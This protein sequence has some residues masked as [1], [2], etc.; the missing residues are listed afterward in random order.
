MKKAYYII[1]IA[2]AHLAA[3][4]TSAPEILQDMD[5]KLNVFVQDMQG[6][7]PSCTKVSYDPSSDRQWSFEVGDCFG[8]FVLDAQNDIVQSNV[9]VYCSGL[10]NDG[11]AVW[12]IFKSISQEGSSSNLP[13]SEVLGSGSRY[14]AYFPYT[15][16]MDNVGNVEQLKSFVQQTGSSLP[17]DQ[18]LSIT[19]CDLLVASNVPDA[20]YGAVSVSGKHVNLTFAH[21]YS[22]LMFDLPSGS[23]KYDYFFGDKDFTPFLLASLEESD[24]YAF[25]FIPG[26]VLDITIKFVHEGKLYKYETGNR[27]NLWPMVT[28]AGH[29]YYLDKSLPAVPYSVA[30]DMGTSVLWSSFNLGAEKV[31][32]VTI[33]TVREYA[34]DYLMW[35]VNQ[36]TSSV[37]NTPYRNYC[38]AFTTGTKPSELPAGYDYSGDVNYDAATALWGGKWRTP[39][40]QEWQELFAACTYIATNSSITFTSKTTGNTLVF[41]YAGYSNGTPVELTKGYY[42]TSD[43]NP[44]NI[45]K[46]YSVTFASNLS[47]RLHPV[48]DR[49][50]G[51]P[52]RPVCS[53]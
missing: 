16:S 28:A 45:A 14:Y 46:A 27:K 31:P 1:L 3:G 9:K 21:V 4:C 33:E 5:W 53:K 29:C 23:V 42:W 44:D 49:Y 38:N 22:M 30:V 17:M 11:N 52:L 18:S 32:S 2:L 50:T 7:V 12:S 26:D 10:D 47:P 43:S 6:D 15:E 51:L 13:I 41:K 20:E 48:A 25:I 8:L 34:G 37:G 40:Y 39:T 24:R 36:V 35:G 19:D